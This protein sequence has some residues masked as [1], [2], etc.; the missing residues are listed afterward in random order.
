MSDN[1]TVRGYVATEVRA[2]VANSG[3][4]ITSFRMCST[5]RR[6]DRAR[7]EWVDG[8]TNWYSVSLFRQLATNAGCSIK[9]GDRVLV[10]GRLRIRPWTNED[11]RSGTTAEIDADAAGHDLMWGTANF[12]RSVSDRND[13]GAQQLQAPED[14]PPGLDLR[15]GELQQLDAAPT[16]YSDMSSSADEED[17]SISSGKEAEEKAGAPF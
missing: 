8:H 14:L 4:A 5:E 9:K 13:D 6:F 17:Q 7:N 15:T 16:D 10:T 11:G 3:L 1:I 2:S 12:R